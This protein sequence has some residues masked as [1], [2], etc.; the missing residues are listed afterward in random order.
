MG[1]YTEVVDRMGRCVRAGR[2]LRCV[3]GVGLTLILALTLTLALILALALALTLTLALALAVAVAVALAVAPSLHQTP[4]R[5]VVR[6]S[7]RTG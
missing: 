7:T 2:V 6:Q 3:R 4:G 1:W 5:T